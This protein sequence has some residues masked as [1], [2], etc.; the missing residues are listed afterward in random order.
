MLSKGRPALL[1]C[2]CPTTHFYLPHFPLSLPQAPVFIP[3]SQPLSMGLPTYKTAGLPSAM[4][5]LGTVILK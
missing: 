3:P 2:S 1:E 4:Q 5:A